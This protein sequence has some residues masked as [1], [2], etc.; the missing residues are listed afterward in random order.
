MILKAIGNAQQV[1]DFDQ[2]IASRLDELVVIQNHLAN[3]E[4]KL[5]HD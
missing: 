5:V 2:T 1:H 4:Q 3:Q